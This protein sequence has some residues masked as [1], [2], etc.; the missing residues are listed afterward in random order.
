VSP[1]HGLSPRPLPGA[2]GIDGLTGPACGLEE[3]TGNR[4]NGSRIAAGVHYL[5][6]DRTSA[7]VDVRQPVGADT[8]LAVDAPS[9]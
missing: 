6:L 2:H 9:G 8:E 1:W 7:R 3:T 5:V 4:F